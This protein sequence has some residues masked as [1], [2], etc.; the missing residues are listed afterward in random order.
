MN[1][2]RR[3][4]D[5]QMVVG[6][7]RQWPICWGQPLNHPLGYD[8]DEYCNHDRQANDPQIVGND[9]CEGCICWH[10]KDLLFNKIC[11]IQLQAGSSLPD[12]IAIVR[13]HRR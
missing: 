5:I 9:F 7:D 11:R 2:N 3:R 4:R 10:A 13:S 1:F 12:P 8:H 6:I